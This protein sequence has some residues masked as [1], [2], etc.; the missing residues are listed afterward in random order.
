MFIFK[1]QLIDSRVERVARLENRLVQAA[2]WT[3][4]EQRLRFQHATILFML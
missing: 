4:P 2:V 3:T 1:K